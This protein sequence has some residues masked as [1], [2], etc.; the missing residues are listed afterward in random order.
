MSV[1]HKQLE[2]KVVDRRKDGGRIV[3]STGAPDRDRDRVFPQGAK[4]EDYLKN[5]VVQFAH[6]YYDPW[7]T[8]GRTRQL[9][10]TETGIV[11]DFEL[12][13]A[14]NDQDPQHK[15]A[16]RERLPG[17]LAAVLTLTAAAPVTGRLAKVVD[18]L[19]VRAAAIIGAAITPDNPAA[20]PLLDLLLRVAGGPPGRGDES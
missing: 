15:Q 13:P 4:T 20:Q 8:V 7:A 16:A 1:V 19:T 6:N 10:I 14:A 5:P 18:E 11:A 12:R 17:E 9:E 2:I 3:I